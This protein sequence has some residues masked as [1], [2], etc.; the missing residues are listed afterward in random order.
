MK[1]TGISLVSN[2]SEILV[3]IIW[4]SGARKR[5]THKNQA[6]F[7][8]SRGCSGQLF[9]LRQITGIKSIFRRTTISTF[10]DMNA[11]FRSVD[12]AA[13]WPRPSLKGVSEIN[14]TN[15]IYS[16]GQN[17]VRE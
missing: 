3:G 7:Q 12:R 16:N 4:L 13:L 5:R 2:A 14:F 8:P 15:L 17:R 10:L 9:I 6:G 11:A 1:I